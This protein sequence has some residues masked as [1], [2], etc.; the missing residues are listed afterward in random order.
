VRPGGIRCRR[1]VGALRRAALVACV[2]AVAGC[3]PRPAPEPLQPIQDW[4]SLVGCYRAGNWR[5]A[6]DSVPALAYWTDPPRGAR[7]AWT[8]AVWAR[9]DVYWTLTPA[10]YAEVVRHNGMDGATT[11]FGMKGDSLIGAEDWWTDIVLPPRPP[12]RVVAVRIP[13]PGPSSGDDP[14]PNPDQL[15][16]TFMH[17]L[18]AMLL[19]SLMPRHP[20]PMLP[21]RNEASRLTHVVSS[22]LS[23]RSQWPPGTVYGLRLDV[24]SDSLTRNEAAATVAIS[25]CKDQPEPMN[26]RVERVRYRFVR[27]PGGWRLVSTE[28]LGRTEGACGSHLPDTPQP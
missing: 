8:Y 6:L 24:E 10:G 15:R 16:L 19:D 27:S 12:D 22:I 28:P 4:R 9:G 11:R 23:S 7:Q 18:S 25:V 3:L 14:P 21:P 17:G 13:C 26:L 1:L 5:F 20:V 2:A